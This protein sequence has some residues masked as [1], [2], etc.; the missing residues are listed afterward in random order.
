MAK[1]KRERRESSVVNR[2]ELL[3]ILDY[4]LKYTDERHPA[5]QKKI[6]NHGV[7][8]FGLEEGIMKRQRVGDCLDFLYSM[9]GHF[10]FSLMQ[11]SGGKYYVENRE[12][13]DEDEI[14]S[15]I[16][17]IKNDRF[18][19]ETEA[20]NLIKKAL[21]SLT[22]EH[23]INYFLDALETSGGYVKKFNTINYKA[24]KK[25]LK[26]EKMIN[27]KLV[28]H[29]FNEN[30]AEIFNRWY[31]V[32]KIKTYMNRPYALLIPVGEYSGPIEGLVQFNDYVYDDVDNLVID[33]SK[34]IISDFNSDRDLN[35]TFLH[36]RTQ[37]KYK[38][39]DELFELGPITSKAY[40]F[41][42]RF[43][44]VMYPFIKKS[45]EEHFGVTLNATLDENEEYYYVKARH[46][47]GSFISWLIRDVHGDGNVSL[48]NVI[49]V[50][51]PKT[52][53]ELVAE[54]FYKGLKEKLDYLSDGNK[55]VLKET[56][57]K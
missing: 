19:T 50:I 33:F 28:I 22:S 54:Y 2:L 15:L 35:E 24:I 52:A 56:L 26:E 31:R 51:N 29:Y 44:R 47:R 53:N 16:S 6:I 45:Y 49:E 46:S 40:D 12:G 9:R 3:I 42:F 43:R 17:A 18:T 11:T 30:K 48:S 7:I 55:E 36:L 27:L 8:H 32:Y 21:G 5:T 38:S 37:V 20:N 39:I 41:E 23:Q 13:F 10:N 25:A 14:F 57:L 34:G 4:L 1:K